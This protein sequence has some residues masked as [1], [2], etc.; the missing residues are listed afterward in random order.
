[1]EEG[2]FWY[3]NSNQISSVKR[4]LN[5]DMEGAGRVCVCGLLIGS[6]CF[7]SCSSSSRVVLVILH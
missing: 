7:V 5:C 1:M 3:Q 2:V 6:Y 4:T